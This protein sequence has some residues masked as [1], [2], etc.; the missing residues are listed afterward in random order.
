VP[1]DVGRVMIRLHA[2][3]SLA[4]ELRSLDRSAL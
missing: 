4:E 2:P 3:E 1:S